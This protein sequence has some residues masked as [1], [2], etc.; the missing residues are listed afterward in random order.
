MLILRLMEASGLHGGSIAGQGWNSVTYKTFRQIAPAVIQDDETEGLGFLLQLIFEDLAVDLPGLFGPAG[1]A[2]LITV[3]SATLRAVIE[4]LNDPQLDSCWTDDMTLGWVYQYWNDPERE[5]LDAKI[6]DGGKIEP[7][8]IA[9]KTQMFTERY[10]VDWL[11]QN[12]LGPMWLAICKRHGWTPEAES[13]GTLAT[14]EQRRVDWRAKRDA[15]EVALTDLMPLHTELERHWAYYVPQ[16]IPDDAVAHAPASVRDVRILDPA[17]GSG[18]F[19]IVAFDLLVALYREE[20]RHRGLD[21]GS[22]RPASGRAVGGD[23]AASWTDRAVVERILE[24]NLHGIDLDPRAVQIAAAALWLKAQSTCR[25]ARPSQLNLVAS[26]LRLGSLPDDDPAL[27]ELRSVVEKETGMPATLTDTIVHSLRGADHLGSLLQIDKA[28]DEAIAA[29]EQQLLMRPVQWQ[30]DLFGTPIQIQRRIDFDALATRRSLLDGL[31]AFLKSH[32]SGEDLGLRTRG[33]Q[34]AAGVRF[35]RMVKAGTYDLVVANPPYQGT[36]KIAISSYIDKH[37]PLGK[38]DLFAAFLLRGLQ[39]VRDGGISSMLTMRNWMFIKQYAELR[40]EL[41]STHGL[42]ALGDFEVGAF[43]EIGGMVVSVCVS[44]FRKARLQKTSVALKFSLNDTVENINRTTRKRAATL[45][46]I[47]RADFNPIALKVIPEWPLVYWWHGELLLYAS[48]PLVGNVCRARAAQSTGDNPRFLRCPWEVPPQRFLVAG[49][50]GLLLLHSPWHPFINGAESKAW[51]EPLSLVVRWDRIAIQV[52]LSKSH[53]SGLD[54]FSLASEDY[55][56]RSGVAFSSTG[57][58]FQARR[59]RFASVY[60]VK[61]QSSFPDNPSEVVCRLNSAKSRSIVCDLNPTISFQVG[62]INRVPL[63]PFGDC[64]V[65]FERIEAAFSDHER[66]RE[67]SVEFTHPGSSP[68]RYAQAWAQLAVDRP[69][70]EPLPEYVEELDPEPPTDHVSFAL[71]VALGRFGAAGEGILDPQTADLSQALPAGVLFLDGTLAE[72]DRRDSLGH[73]AAACLDQAWAEH[74][75]Q[76]APRLSLRDWLRE[77]FFA[78]VHRQMY[79]NRPIHWPLSSAKKTF[80]AWVN[81]HRMDGSTLRVL[82]ADHLQ[83]TLMRLEGELQDL[84]GA[85]DGLDKSA[86]RDAEKRLAQVQGW[87]DELIEFIRLV[88]QCGERG[89]PPADP[90]CPPREVDA[91]YEPDLDDGVMINSAALWPLL[92]PQWKD[93]KKWWKELSEASPKG[94][95]DYDWSHLAMRYWP[96]R[97]DKKCQDDPSLGV[98]HGC[99]RKY[100]PERAWAWELR[101]QDEIGPDFRIR[102]TPYRGDGGDDS[103]RDAFLAEHPGIALAAIE[104]E[105]SRRIRKSDNPVHELRILEPGVWSA[106]PDRCFAL[107]LRNSGPRQA[108][109]RLQAPDSDASRERFLTARPAAALQLVREEILSRVSSREP[110][111]E[112]RLSDPGLWREVPELCW[113]LEREVTRIQGEQPFRLTDPDSDRARAEFVST[114]SE[115]ALAIVRQ[116]LAARPLTKQKPLAEYLIADAGL[117][118]NC[119]EACYQLELEIFKKQKRP[120]TLIDPDHEAQRTAFEAANPEQAKARRTLLDAW[121]PPQLFAM[122]P[123]AKPKR[124][125]RAKS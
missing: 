71:G 83:P 5:A 102:E 1:T 26:N 86:A 99:F 48:Y 3:P 93:P 70:G 21:P 72:S 98:A 80:V 42:H 12:S 10:M 123:E 91:R 63:L 82:L 106:L 116:D 16:P 61:G 56:Y 87:R 28:V 33:E 74:G 65:V 62:D 108:D 66:F 85:W 76:I 89:A 34:L 35:M 115:E 7:H 95:K 68:W 38:S 9:S 36:S 111:A 121:Q 14:L 4:A 58:A 20:A 107:E 29:H 104:K 122:E 64:D 25:D 51:I 113:S 17:V 120:L 100:H 55:F 101:L 50:D 27:V 92:D 88:E 8:E 73:P 109:F 105:L 117:W 78:D 19:L 45:C 32:S 114:R 30:P 23:G 97:V 81:I 15:G 43:E 46:H 118:A 41:L 59:H 22:P 52:K 124:G 103:H 49:S 84:R 57:S 39:L 2:E 90:K 40:E 77:K 31:E 13:S 96:T 60:D 112:F 11:L 75:D 69:E 54:A 44:I 24:H 110:L 67:S 79:E 37:Y 18:H 53:K 47:G 6:N 94:N 119:A 125:R